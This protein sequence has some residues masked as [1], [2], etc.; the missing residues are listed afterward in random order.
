MSSPNTVPVTGTRTGRKKPPF[1]DEVQ[2]ITGYNRK[3][4]GTEQASGPAGPARR[5][6]QDGQTQTTQ[7]EGEKIYTDQVIASLRLIWAFF[8]YTCGKLLAP[9]IRQHMPFIAPW[10]AFGITPSIRKK[11]LSINPATIDRALKG[12]SLCI[13][14]QVILPKHAPSME[15]SE[16][17]MGF[18]MKEKQTLTRG[19][20]P[21]YRQ[22]ENRKKKT[23]ILNEFIR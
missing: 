22:A 6:R 10:P 12:K 3:Y 20:T 8:W 15:G 4:A 9:L 16:G 17:C 2:F 18:T 13:A 14:S 5:Q 19:Y 11:F 23:S 1:W 7:P 21:Q